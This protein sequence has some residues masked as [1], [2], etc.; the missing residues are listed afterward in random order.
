M[1][2]GITGASPAADWK[3][4]RCLRGMGVPVLDADEVATLHQQIR[5]YIKNAILEAFVRRVHQ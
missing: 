3:R 1:I 2:V 5:A 4:A